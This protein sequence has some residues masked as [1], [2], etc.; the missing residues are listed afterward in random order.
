MFLNNQQKRLKRI[1]IVD[2]EG[3]FLHLFEENFFKQVYTRKYKFT[4]CKNVPTALREIKNN[5]PDLILLDIQMSPMRGFDLLNLLKRFRVKIPTI[6]ISAYG[7]EENRSQAMK[8]RAY[9]FFQKHVDFKKLEDAINEFFPFSDESTKD[10]PEE[11]TNVQTF[12]M[13]AALTRVDGDTALLREIVE[14]FFMDASHHMEELQKSIDDE[15]AAC[16]FQ[17]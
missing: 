5:R 2:D 6:I 10:S 12:D 17:L 14:L 16:R 15:D 13:E 9:D 3:S 4:Y 11:K 8:L 7:D 1:L